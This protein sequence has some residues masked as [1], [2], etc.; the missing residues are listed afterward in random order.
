[1]TSLVVSEPKIREW[2]GNG[3]FFKVMPE[4]SAMR[5][6]D[7]SPRQVSGCPGCPARTIRPFNQVADFLLVL[8]SLPPPA[9]DR[10]KR[11]AGVD[12]ILYFTTNP[13]TRAPEVI[14]R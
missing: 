5:E 7:Y 9:I 14:S 8:R 3:A 12:T 4:F 2:A 11:F 13:R 10:L 6:R 1:M